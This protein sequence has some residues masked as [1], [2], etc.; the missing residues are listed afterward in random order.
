MNYKMKKFILLV[1]L[2][3]LGLQIVPLLTA[4]STTSQQ[5]QAEVAGL[6]AAIKNV[7]TK[8]RILRD[9]FLPNESPETVLDKAKCSARAT[10]LSEV[11]QELNTR[12]IPALEALLFNSQRLVIAPMGLPIPAK[13]QAPGVIKPA[14]A[15][16]TLVAV[17][18]PASI[19]SSG[20]DKII[21]QLID[22]V[23]EEI[24]E[25]SGAVDSEIAQ[26]RDELAILRAREK[27]RLDGE[28]A[29]FM[30]LIKQ[31][32]KDEAASLPIVAEVK[33]RLVIYRY[34][35]ER[36]ARNVTSALIDVTTYGQID[37]KK[38]VFLKH[39]ANLERGCAEVGA[40]AEQLRAACDALSKLA[41]AQPANSVEV[42]RRAEQSQCHTKMIVKKSEEIQRLL[43]ELKKNKELSI[44]AK[45][46]LERQFE[47]A[48][49]KD[50]KKE[51]MEL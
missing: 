7:A 13:V 14:P 42:Q 48:K 26:L 43:V 47:A 28:Y 44:Q 51:R 12:L 8:D 20:E 16:Q 3:A 25:D 29:T 45:F 19:R 10:R 36:M 41:K 37:G 27:E 6:M 30:A 17:Q 15:V 5:Y 49:A 1:G 40:V 31:A 34:D 21:D 2:V 50:R 33:E 9:F 22:A 46:D 11:A 39:I 4:A 38:A 23:E 18:T 24:E 32:K 35:L